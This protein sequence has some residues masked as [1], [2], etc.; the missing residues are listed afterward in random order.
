MKLD[1]CLLHRSITALFLLALPAVVQAQFTFTTNN[2]SITITGYTGPGGVVVIPASINS[3][4]VTSTGAGAFEDCLSLTS[5]TIPDSVTSIGVQTFAECEGLTNIVIPNSVTNI[6]GW[7]F[8]DCPGLT[9]ITIPSS[10]TTIGE[11]SA[12]FGCTSL[13]NISVDPA[14]PAYSSLNGVLFDEAQDTLIAYPDGLTNSTYTIP[15]SV[16]SIGEEAFINCSSLSSVTVP[17]RVTNI[18]SAAFDYC[19]GLTNIVLPNGLTS[20]GG[21]AFWNCGLTSITIPNSV[22][23]IGQQAFYV[24]KSL[25]RVTILSSAISIGPFAF[26]YCSSLTSAYFGGNPPPDNGNSF[27]GDP[28]A[29]IYYTFGTTGWGV[30][31]GGAPTMGVTPASEFEYTTN[32]NSITITHYTGPSGVVGIPASIN[33]LP[34]TSIGVGAFEDC[35]SLTSITIP[36][37]VTSLGGWAFLGCRSLASVTIPDSVTN[38]G[39]EAFWGCGLTSVTILSS[40]ISIG[41]TA[42]ADC[43]NLTSAYFEGNAPADNGNSFSGD[44]GAI[45]YYSLG[46]TGWGATFGGAP[47]M[48]VTPVSEFEYTTNDDSITITRYTGRGGPVLIPAIA[49]SLPVT[50]IGTGAFEDFNTPTSITIPNSVTSIGGWA[51]LGCRSLASVTI[52]DSVTNIGPEAFWACG[53]TSVTIPSSVTSIATETFVDCSS[54]TNVAI[55]NSVTSIGAY[56]FQFCTNLTS[57]YFAGNAPPDDGTAFSDDPAIVYY[58]PGTTGWGPTFG[59]VP[60]ELWNPQATAFTTAGGQFGF[61]ITGPTNATIVVETCTNLANPVWLPISTNMLS[62]GVSSFRDAQSTNCPNRYYRFSA[63]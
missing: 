60:T 48:G 6:G 37:S 42:F 49:N 61:S 27:S 30:T 2:G 21:S 39:T 53:L 29:I 41:G 56:A 45:V 50:S 44:T 22:T 38:I 26:E 28:E 35:S 19:T 12:F 23:S 11:G 52:P 20:I 5:V 16:S 40:A 25:T 54:L 1:I 17:G 58:L 57:A 63:P 43:A 32:D 51:F 36:N 4:P 34:V 7:A 62:G 13:T 15:N 46:T 33:S 3:L 18:G 8:E 59:G 31:F 55:P 10:V 9:S 14:N 47:T 24:C